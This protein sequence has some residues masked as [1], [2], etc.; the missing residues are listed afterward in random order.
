MGQ[1][2]ARNKKATMKYEILD[3]Y[4]VGLS[5]LGQEV[6]GIRAGNIEMENSFV[7]FKGNTPMVV[8]LTITPPKNL[9]TGDYDKERSRNLLLSKS[10][11]R[12]IKQKVNLERLT[13]IPLSIY[14]T[15]G[16]IKMEIGI[17]KGRN[18]AD[19]RNYLKEKDF[20]RT[21]KEYIR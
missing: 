4:E 16:L 7:S 19:K 10:E 5:L 3:K 20:Q 12:K 11:I 1:T 14:S 8:N 13:I 15:R 17:A 9:M 18:K 6:K 2:Y 21:K